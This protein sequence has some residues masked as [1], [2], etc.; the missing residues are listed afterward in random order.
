LN[1]EDFDDTAATLCDC[2]C[3]YRLVASCNYIH[4]SRIYLAFDRSAVSFTWESL[5]RIKER[6]GLTGSYPW[7]KQASYALSRHLRDLM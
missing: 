5:V 3:H 7:L 1:T 2:F 4:D 6:A